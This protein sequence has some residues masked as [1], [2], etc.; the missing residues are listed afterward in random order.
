MLIATIRL[1]SFWKSC[2]CSNIA[3]IPQL[4]YRASVIGECWSSGEKRTK[5]T[6][7]VTLWQHVIKQKRVGPSMAS[8]N[9][10]EKE[11]EQI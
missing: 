2:T 9:M 1:I 4:L 10:Y 5:K 7:A 8:G 11:L 3:V 6:P